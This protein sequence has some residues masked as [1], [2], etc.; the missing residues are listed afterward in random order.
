MTTSYCEFTISVP[1]FFELGLDSLASRSESRGGLVD[2]GVQQRSGV[3][4]LLDCQRL[5]WL[6][7]AVDPL[8]RVMRLGH[9][10]LLI[11]GG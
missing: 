1:I 10:I 11:A 8:D 7:A 5:S 3:E 4:E 2:A 9:W 6:V